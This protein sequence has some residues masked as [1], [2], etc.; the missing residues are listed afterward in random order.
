VP[1]PVVMRVGC[2]WRA[3]SSISRPD[4]RAVF[5]SCTSTAASQVHGRFTRRAF[6]WQVLLRVLGWT[7]VFWR[8]HLSVS[9]A[10]S[11]SEHNTVRKLY[12]ICDSFSVLNGHADQYGI[13]NRSFIW[14]PCS[15]TGEQPCQWF[16]KRT[17]VGPIQLDSGTFEPYNVL[18]L[19]NRPCCQSQ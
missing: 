13:R 8:C 11:F 18:P 7:G 6:L 12:S 17:L 2:L 15:P 1:L 19:A 10:N 16:A 4:I 5:P 3:P 14:H 9:I